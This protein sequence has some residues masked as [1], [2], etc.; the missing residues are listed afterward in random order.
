MCEVGGAP[1]GG[2]TGAF[3]ASGA[4]RELFAPRARDES[5]PPTGR[6]R[7]TGFAR[8]GNAPPISIF[9]VLPE[10]I[11]TGRAR[12]KDK[13]EA[14]G[15]P[16]ECAPFIGAAEETCCVDV[17]TFFSARA[18]RMAGADREHG[19]IAP[20]GRGDS[21]A[22][23]DG[24]CTVGRVRH[25]RGRDLGH[26]PGMREARES[27]L[28][29]LCLR[30]RFSPVLPMNGENSGGH[31]SVSLFSSTVHGA[32]SFLSQERET[33]PPRGLPRGERR[34][35]RSFSGS[36]AAG[37]DGAAEFLLTT[38]GGA[39]PDTPERRV[40]RPAPEA[41]KNL[42]PGPRPEN[43]RPAPEAR[44]PPSPRRGAIPGNYRWSVRPAR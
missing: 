36:L 15:C 8:A 19:E 35:K 41:R 21:A 4:G 30:S 32:F 17:R 1:H 27:V 37:G 16:P 7:R 31:P 25:G 13:R 12:S 10:K 38:M 3:R 39:S 22:G 29:A 26:R 24:G 14:P 23:G 40:V 34:K 18:S 33:G 6:G 9:S 11:E 28:G 2:G 42:V 44:K 5:F 43:S 20:Q